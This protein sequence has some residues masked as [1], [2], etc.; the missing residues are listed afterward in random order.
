VRNRK[1][2][3]LMEV[4]ERRGKERRNWEKWREGKP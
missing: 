1:G 2:L 3:I 4:E